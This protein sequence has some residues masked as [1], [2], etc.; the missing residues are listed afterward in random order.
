MNLKEL[1][2][3]GGIV[4]AA[5]VKRSV[6]WTHLDGEG[7]TVVDAFDVH[8]KKISFAV[9]DRARASAAEQSQFNMTAAL[10]SEAVLLGEKADEQLTYEQATQ[11]HPNLAS[12]LSTAMWAVNGLREAEKK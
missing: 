11:L 6:E 5:L 2:E 3:K 1:M 9:V 8:I 10:I 4:D 7:K 12:A